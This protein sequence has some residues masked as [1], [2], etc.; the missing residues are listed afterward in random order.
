MGQIVITRRWVGWEITRRLELTDADYALREKRRKDKK[1]GEYEPR[2]LGW[3]ERFMRH[4]E[5]CPYCGKQPHC[6]CTWNARDGYDYKL[7]CD[8]YP[9][10]ML[11]CGDWYHQLSRAGLDWNFRVRIERGEPRKVCPHWKPKR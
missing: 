11:D 9:N 8:C 7:M 5:P 2:V 1:D 10:G 4:L 3:Q 6:N